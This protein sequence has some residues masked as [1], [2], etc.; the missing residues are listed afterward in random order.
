MNKFKTMIGAAAIALGS[1][2][3][4]AGVV[5]FGGVTWDEEAGS[6]LS[7]SFAFN[8]WYTSD[9]DDFTS[10]DVLPVPSSLADIGAELFAFGEFTG[11][12]SGRE[13]QPTDNTAFT[14]G[15][16][17]TFTLTGAFFDPT[18][19]DAG[20]LGLVTTG[21]LLNIYID[22]TRDLS[23]TDPTDW[24]DANNDGDLWASFSFDFFN[25]SGALLDAQ[26]VAGLSFESS[27][28]AGS[29]V[30]DTNVDG[31]D[32]LLNSS[33]QFNT[34][35]QTIAQGANGQ[36]LRNVIP[37]PTSIAMLALGLLGLAGARRKQS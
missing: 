2:G 31:P 3:A 32:F 8:Q 28:F 29:E 30:L 24:A 34:D 21:A 11:F 9:S 4:N 1:F 18:H 10:M 16:E 35:N 26:L 6:P 15:A 7:A 5:S 17:L 25:L 36:I 14:D 20:S 23:Q 37:E 22:D 19:P 12:S 27:S 33:A 13:S